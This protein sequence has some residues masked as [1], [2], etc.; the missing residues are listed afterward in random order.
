MLHKSGAPT[1]LSYGK[2]KVGKSNSF[3]VYYLYIFPV[4]KHFF[5]FFYFLRER[6]D[7]V[8]LLQF[9][10]FCNDLFDMKIIFCSDTI[11]KKKI[12]INKNW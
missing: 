2:L 6:E 11:L 4:A 10:D 9:G 1:F 7:F 12:R 5:Y 8:A 3:S